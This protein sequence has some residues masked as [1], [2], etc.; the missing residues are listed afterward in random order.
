MLS[1][2]K[3]WSV[4]NFGK[5]FQFV[6]SVLDLI[7]GSRSS[8]PGLMSRKSPT[9][10]QGVQVSGPSPNEKL[11]TKAI[12]PPGQRDGYVNEHTQYSDKHNII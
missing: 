7:T 11:Q 3:S 6:V 12:Q 8:T 9:I 1:V 10:D 4:E 2:T 5:S